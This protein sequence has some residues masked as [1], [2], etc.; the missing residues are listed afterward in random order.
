VTRAPANR[1]LILSD[2]EL[3]HYKRALARLNNPA[4]LDQITDRVFC[5]DIFTALPHL[6]DGCV[7]LMFA[8]PPY[9]LTKS[10]NDRRFKKISIDAYAE[11]LDS[12]LSQTVRLL[13]KKASVYV[14]GDWESS[15]AIHRVGEKYFIP[16][17]RITWERE[18]GRGAKANWKKCAED[19]WFFTVSDD[20]Y[21]D[22]DAVRLKKQVIAPYTDPNGAPKDWV[23]SPDGRFRLTHPSNLWTDL[24]VPYWSMPENT[25]HPTQKPEKLLAKIVLASSKPGDLVF[26]PFNGAGTTTVVAK[27]LGRR[28]LGVEVEEIFCCYAQKR[29]DLADCDATIQGYTE[30]VF[31]ERNTFASQNRRRK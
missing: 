30:G 12:W 7:D 23:E 1:T 27:K 2:K 9:N 15:A 10:F 4:T 19:V 14:C 16:R 26:D 21:F 29:L 20:Y 22:V 28:Y 13:K 3:A 11:W 18:K 31:W 17:N 24:T 8:D 6:P 5:Q 25:D